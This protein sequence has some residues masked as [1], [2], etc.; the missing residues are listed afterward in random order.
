MVEAER[1]ELAD[2]SEQ[3]QQA[4][5]CCKELVKALEGALALICDEL[6]LSPMLLDSSCFGKTIQTQEA[7]PQVSEALAWRCLETSHNS[8][9]PCPV[10]HTSSTPPVL[11]AASC[12]PQ[13]CH[14]GERDD[15]TNI[16]EQVFEFDQKL[17]E[18]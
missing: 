9:A 16:R 13:Q 18:S 14:T 8:D 10:R 7:R 12:R 2:E 6:Q 11:V 5:A 1:A 17:K 3:R 4:E 15:M